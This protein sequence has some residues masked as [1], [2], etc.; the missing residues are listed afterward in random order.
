VVDVQRG[1]A[2]GVVS[3]GYRLITRKEAIEL[4]KS[5]LSSQCVFP[6]LIPIPM[7]ERQYASVKPEL[8]RSARESAGYS[9]ERAAKRIGLRARD[10]LAQMEAGERRPTVPQLRKAARV[11]KRPLAV[12]FLSSPP[13]TPALPHDFRRLADQ[14]PLGPFP[15]LLL[16]MRRARRRRT[17][18]LELLE[19]LGIP[20]VVEVA[21]GNPVICACR[22]SRGELP[23]LLTPPQGS[24]SEVGSSVI[25]AEAGTQCRC[26][27]RRA[28]G[29]LRRPRSSAG[30]QPARLPI[31]RGSAD[32]HEA[33]TSTTK[34]W[35]SQLLRSAFRSCAPCST[36]ICG[37]WGLS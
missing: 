23:R 36:T 25:P 12:F 27:A 17:V 22:Q 15:E 2:L 34:L 11:Y 6:V 31:R 3:N 1:S 30:G 16:E 29:R 8:L 32:E 19:E 37:R 5:A 13:A 24:F 28:T 21:G 33:T 14:E 18:A 10:R 7:P 4:G 35:T 9:L 26:R 20:S